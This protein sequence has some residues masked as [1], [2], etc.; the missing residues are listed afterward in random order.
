MNY[1][2]FCICLWIKERILKRIYILRH[3][4]SSW[5][6]PTLADLQRPLNKRGR[7][8][9][10]LMASIMKRFEYI[11]DVIYL[12][13]SMR[14][15][16]TIEPVVEEL[17]ISQEN[18]F[19]ESSLY[20]GY[21]DDYESVIWGVNDEIDSILMVGHNPGITYIANSC[22]GPIIDNVP[23]CGLLVINSQVEKWQKFHFSESKLIA[24]HYPKMYK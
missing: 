18:V 21:Y 8:D 24:F 16:L 12:S 4:K 9:A 20:H 13:P 14:T 23:T 10:P 19:L 7:R 6:D 3:A 2:S 1:G 17:N 15:R 22:D 5:S 11:P